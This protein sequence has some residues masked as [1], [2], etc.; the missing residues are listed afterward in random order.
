PAAGARRPGPRVS[1]GGAPLPGKIAL[2]T[3]ASRGI[4]L[5]VA[6]ALHAAGAHVVRLARPLSD[7]GAE[8]RTDL[9]CDVGARA[10]VERAGP[11]V[12]ADTGAAAVVG[13]KAGLLLQKPGEQ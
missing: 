13:N 12:V 10:A 2:V 5:A 6:N 9:R 4:G 8:R 7:G 1:R 3:G 11:R